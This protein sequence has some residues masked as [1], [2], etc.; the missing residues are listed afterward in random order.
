MKTGSRGDVDGARP[1]RA[2]P[3]RRGE[4]AEGGR[5]GRGTGA[6]ASAWRVCSGS[7][8]GTVTDPLQCVVERRGSP[9][10]RKKK[11][12]PGF[13][14][15]PEQGDPHPNP[16]GKGAGLAPWPPQGVATKRLSGR[17]PRPQVLDI[18]LPERERKLE[19]GSRVRAASTE[20]RREWTVFEVSATPES[21]LL[22]LAPR[23]ARGPRLPPQ[24][25]FA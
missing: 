7:A 4:G 18:Q 12:V 21:I 23:G 17:G 8:G 20:I 11:E 2:C 14:H 10:K 15:P 6:R 24:R 3:A 13:Q 1:R 25:T 22:L 19:T 9:L 5:G 16:S